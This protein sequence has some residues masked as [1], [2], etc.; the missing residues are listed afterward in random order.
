MKTSEGKS[1]VVTMVDSFS[2]F[3]ILKEIP[4]KEATTVAKCF[5]ENWLSMFGSPLSIVSDMGKDLNTKVMQGICDYLQIDKKIT[6]PQH[7]QS[8]S[9]AEVLKKKLAKYLKSMVE[10]SLLEWPKLLSACQYAYNLSVHRALKNSP[11][12]VLFGV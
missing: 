1:Y 12:C 8:N 9:Q 11:Y 10:K 7:A 6:T 3:A 5:W 2:K 4:N